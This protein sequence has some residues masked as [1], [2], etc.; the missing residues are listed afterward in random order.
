M[1]KKLALLLL[2]MLA[3][4]TT[5]CIQESLVIPVATVTG[6]VIVPSGKISTGV[7]V[8][9]AGEPSLSAYVDD[10]GG[11]SIEFRKSGRFL[12]IARGQNFDASYTWVD[13]VS[14]QTVSAPDISL[15]EKLVGEALWIATIVDYPDATGFAVKSVSPVWSQATEK[16]YDDGT[17]G[18]RLA[19]DGIF[20]L[21]LNNLKTGAQQYSLDVTMS[22]G[23]VKNDR[24]PHREAMIANSSMIYIPESTVKLARGQVTSDLVSVNYSEVTLAT[25]KGS[26]SMKLDSDGGYSFAMEGNGREYLVFRSPNFHAR[27]IPVDLS[28]VPLLEVPMTTLASKKSGEIKMILIASDFSEVVN[29]TVVGDFT[30]WQPQKLYDDGTNGDEVAGDGVYTRLFTGVNTSNAYQKYAFNINPTNQDKDPY[31]E[32]SDPSYSIIMVK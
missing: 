25:K 5:G 23:S 27:A 22:D 17:H 9:V 11:Y 18:D 29:P 1:K 7:K 3:F 4:V 6:K 13:A 21:R 12:L 24:D 20:T 32:S 10:R 26:R 8:T 30:N 19:N 2:T 14:E 28:T 15:D 16:M 31:Q